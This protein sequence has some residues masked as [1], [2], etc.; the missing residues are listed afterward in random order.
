M[1][2]GGLENSQT[3]IVDWTHKTFDK[4]AAAYLVQNM[5]IKSNPINS[6]ISIYKE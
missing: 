4:A 6:Y 3:L 1:A 5:G 2:E